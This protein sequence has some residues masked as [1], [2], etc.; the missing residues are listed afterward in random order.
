MK[1]RRFLTTIASVPAAAVVMGP[2][3]AAAGQGRGGQAGAP[4]DA[5]QAAIPVPKGTLPDAVA[6]PVPRFFTEEQFATLKK[7]GE[8]LVPARNGAPGAVEAGAPEFLDFFIGK[9]PADRQQLYRKGL[10]DLNAQARTGHKKPFAALDAAQIDAILKPLFKPYPER[11]SATA[12]GPFVN[13]VRVELRTATIN[14]PETAAAAEASGRRV[15]FGLYWRNI[16]PTVL[17]R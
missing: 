6:A 12:F 1:R 16:D 9:S 10:D 17:S 14:S 4:A 13:E 2:R 15:A 11:R 3:P 7:L 5:G 8:V